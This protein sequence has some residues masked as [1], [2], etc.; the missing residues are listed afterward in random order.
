MFYT[1]NYFKQHNEGNEIIDY[2][3]F[4][5]KFSNQREFGGDFSHMDHLVKNRFIDLSSYIINIILRKQPKL[6]LDVGC[7]LG[8]NL[9]ISRMFPSITY[10]GID[11]AED[12]LRK[13]KLQYPNVKF[14]VGDAFDMPFNPGTF[15]LCIISSVLILYKEASDRRALILETSR[16]MT[17][18]GV[19][20]AI[21]WNNSHML[22][23]CIQL[24]R[25]IGRL[26]G[27][28]L[29]EDFMG[30]HF[31]NS[32]L[33]FLAESAGLE[34][35][36]IYNTS[37]NYG[38]LESVRYLNMSKYNRKFGVS[39]GGV[40]PKSQNLF[41]D[42]LAQSGGPKQLLLPL[43]YISRLAPQLFSMFTICVCKKR[44]SYSF[45]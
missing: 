2:K 13:A 26:F 22:R 25:L 37:A 3:E 15:D 30:I 8:M 5:K 11:Y 9:P 6:I 17:D 14:H 35:C 31:S 20:V 1:Y 23:W 18:D 43:F 29:P 19:L 10:Q 12:T 16:V 7:G 32:E 4:Y 45:K 39:E 36:Q 42:L 27:V 28:K 41:N 33:K 38:L 34:V 21:V 44:S 24:S 40:G